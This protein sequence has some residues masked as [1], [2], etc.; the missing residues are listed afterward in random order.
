MK[1]SLIITVAAVAALSLSGCATIKENAAAAAV[2][3][4]NFQC[5]RTDREKLE[6][7]GLY[8]AATGRVLVGYCEGDDGYDDAVK[9][10]ITDP[11]KI[12][13]KVVRGILSGDYQSVI[14]VL[15]KAGKDNGDLELDSVGCVIRPS[16]WRHCPPTKP[17]PRE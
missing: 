12:H 6:A 16:G 3:V 4:A 9:K 10:F 17:A 7:R 1:N 5:D 2:G 14:P 8:H 15:L 11:Q 13:G